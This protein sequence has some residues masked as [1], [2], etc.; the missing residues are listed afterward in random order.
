MS[1]RK[2]SVREIFVTVEPNSKSYFLL[3]F[4]LGNYFVLLSLLVLSNRFDF[5]VPESLVLL[6]GSAAVGVDLQ[7]IATT[8]K[9]FFK[10]KGGAHHG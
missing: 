9:S 7:Q 10:A 3:L 6:V 1:K 4:R 8:L 5:H 2:K